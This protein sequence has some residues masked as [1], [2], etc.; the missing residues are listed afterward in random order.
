MQIIIT[1]HDNSKQIINNNLNSLPNE[2][3]KD[4]AFD[5]SNGRYLTVEAVI[6]DGRKSTTLVNSFEK[7]E[8]AKK[9]IDNRQKVAA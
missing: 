4:I 5:V 2:I 3:V 9:A 6:N 7:K 1:H 8:R